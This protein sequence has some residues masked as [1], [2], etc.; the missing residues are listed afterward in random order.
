MGQPALYAA[1]LL[2]FYFFA[3][4]PVGSLIVRN[5][6][7]MKLASDS[8]VSLISEIIQGIRTIKLYAWE[9]SLL[10]RA[11]AR[12]KLQCRHLCCF[13]ALTAFTDGFFK[14]AGVILYLPVLLG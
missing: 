4:F 3:Q 9:Q 6:K 14:N 1:P 10:A 7:K 2:A 13:Y 12:R 11:Y 8:R 5:Q